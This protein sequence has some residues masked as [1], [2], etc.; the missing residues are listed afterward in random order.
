MTENRVFYF[1][2][3]FLGFY[4]ALLHPSWWSEEAKRE[5]HGTEAQKDHGSFMEL[6]IPG[7]T[8]LPACLSKR[9][10]GGDEGND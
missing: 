5:D 4:S 10:C 6:I 3:R 7:L 9:S 2:S 8:L 1:L